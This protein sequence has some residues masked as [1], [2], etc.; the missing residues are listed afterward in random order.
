MHAIEVGKG[1]VKPLTGWECQGG[2]EK[3]KRKTV[4]KRHKKQRERKKEYKKPK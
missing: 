3:R 2:E 4:N 1:A